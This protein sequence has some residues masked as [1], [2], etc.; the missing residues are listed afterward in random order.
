MALIYYF[1]VIL[2]VVKG[3]LAWHR[4]RKHEVPEADEGEFHRASAAS[5][6][7]EEVNYFSIWRGFG[8]GPIRI[9][10]QID[11]GQNLYSLLFYSTLRTE[12]ILAVQGLLPVV[13][14][15]VNPEAINADKGDGS[16]E[17]RAEAEDYAEDPLLEGGE[18]EEGEYI[19]WMEKTDTTF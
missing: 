19:P 1:V 6:K 18:K 11:I 3:G 13:R 12:Y 9:G 4:D 14:D 10:T 7:Q 2:K 5:E 15:R 17:D 8:E 16:V